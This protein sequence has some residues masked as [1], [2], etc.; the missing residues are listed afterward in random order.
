METVSFLVDQI[1]DL[2]DDNDDCDSL[3][4]ECPSPPPTF[5]SDDDE[6]LWDCVDC[7]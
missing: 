2:T 1:I 3:Q 6:G 4:V 7:E 5:E